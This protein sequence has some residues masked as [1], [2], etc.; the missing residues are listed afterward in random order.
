MLVRRAVVAFRERRA[1]AGLPFPRRSSAACDATVQRTCL[2]LLLDEGNG[3]GYAFVKLG[4]I[5]RAV[6]DAEKAL[7]CG[8]QKPQERS[9]LLWNAAR[10]FA[11]AG[12][13]DV[14]SASGRRL[15]AHHRADYQ[16]RALL[17]LRQALALTPA[18]QRASSDG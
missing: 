5:P 13:L 15:P 10:I 12:R 3:R 2:D 11:Q 16:D 14:D 9:R 8:S 7:R 1:L 18:E 4:A 6:E 17:L